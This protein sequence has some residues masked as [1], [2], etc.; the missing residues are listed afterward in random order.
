MSYGIQQPAVSSQILLLEQDLGAKLF[1]RTPFR[2]TREGEELYSFVRPFFEGLDAMSARLRKKSAP[3]LR[4]G[5]AE[6]VLRDYLP[7][8]IKQLRKS[9]EGIQLVLRSG[10]SA[11][12]EQWLIDGEIDLAITPWERRPAAGLR[13][14][15]LVRRPLALLV[16][17]SSKLRS[18]EEL[19]AQDRIDTPLIRLPAK[20]TITRLFQEG[21]KKLSV[22]W[23]L[24]I[25]ASLVD[26]IT[27]YVANEYGIGLTVNVAEWVKKA[28]VRLLP[29]DDFAP[30]EI[31]A[32]WR[33]KATPLIEDVLTAARAEVTRRWPQ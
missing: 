27:E 16:P 28:K 11:A 32:M 19:W 15:R 24:S 12:M 23:P 21:L 20:E 17:L 33:G 3:L 8:V 29:L 18:A 31:V 26:L 14:Q 6:F 30:V 25:E 22:D 4:L 7:P 9:H 13:F 2:L 10:F 1:E 5:A